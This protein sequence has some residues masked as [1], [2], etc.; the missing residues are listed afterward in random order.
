MELPC[1]LRFCVPLDFFPTFAAWWP[2]RRYVCPHDPAEIPQFCPGPVVAKQIFEAVLAEV[3]LLEQRLTNT[4]MTMTGTWSFRDVARPLAA[5]VETLLHEVQAKVTEVDLHE[6]AVV[7]DTPQDV[8]V[9]LPVWIAGQ[10]RKAIHA[11]L[12]KVWLTDVEGIA[13]SARVAQHQEIGDLKDVFEAFHSQWKERWCKHDQLPFS[14]WDSVLGFAQ[15]V[16]HPAPVPHLVITPELILAESHKKKKRS[17]TGLDGVSRDDLIQADACTLQSLAD[18]YQRA[19]HDGSWPAQLLAGKVHSLPKTEAA[20]TVGQFRPI[21]VFGLPYRTWSSLQSRHLLQWAEC[22]VDDGVFGN[23]RGCQ[24][25]DLWHYLLQQI[26]HAYATEQPL[27]GISADLEKC[28][29]CIPRFPAL[30]LAVLAGTPAPVTTAWA[31][32]L[33]NMCRHFKVH[34]TPTPKGFLPVRALLRVVG[35]VCVVC[36][37]WTTCFPA[38]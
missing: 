31:G 35:S 7:L 22:W 15:R 1:G 13:P 28:F 18:M 17:A 29:N 19:E 6:C 33:A 30:C 26:E 3:R 24:A 25:S 2:Q 10:P 36:C 16:M 20:S 12:D 8:D 32:S 9:T 11:E 38:G 14:H 4:N 37:C 27:C 5:P 23:R 21:T 34:R